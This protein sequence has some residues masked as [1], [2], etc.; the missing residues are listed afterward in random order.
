VRE[1]EEKVDAFEAV[2]IHLG[3]RREV[4]HRVEADRRLGIGAFPD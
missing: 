3:F 2:A 1:R 4:E